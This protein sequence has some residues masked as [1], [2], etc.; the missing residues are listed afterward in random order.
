MTQAWQHEI[1]QPHWYH[2]LEEWAN[3]LRIIPLGWHRSMAWW[4]CHCRSPS[5]IEPWPKKIDS[6]AESQKC[7]DILFGQ[8]VN[9]GALQRA[10]PTSH[11][12]AHLH[13]LSLINVE[14]NLKFQRKSECPISQTGWS[15][16]GRIQPSPT[17]CAGD[18]D[19]ANL[20]L[21]GV[22]VREGKDHD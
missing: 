3:N 6:L 10:W 20:H 21:S 15:S 4:C 16:F 14:R 12:L 9:T 19:T 13:G 11:T 17:A 22:W 8:S 5:H 1:Y 18:G 7:V 2:T